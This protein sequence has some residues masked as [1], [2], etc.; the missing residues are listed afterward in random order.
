MAILCVGCKVYIWSTTA[1]SWVPGEVVDIDQGAVTL[2]Y[3][4]DNL[5]LGKTVG[6]HSIRLR[7]KPVARK[8]LAVPP[9]GLMNPD[10]EAD[11]G[12]PHGLSGQ[13]DRHFGDL[14]HM[15]IE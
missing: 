12:A 10:T 14:G 13:T 6:Q 3:E 5:L 7:T 15:R 4:F 9:H 11:P 1:C 8:F 2:E